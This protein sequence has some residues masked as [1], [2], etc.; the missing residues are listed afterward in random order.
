MEG[1]EED[2]EPLPS[3]MGR[4]GG[5]GSTPGGSATP[6]GPYGTSYEV[7]VCVCMYV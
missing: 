4:H 7:R 1:A 6:G 3:L 5:A 2:P